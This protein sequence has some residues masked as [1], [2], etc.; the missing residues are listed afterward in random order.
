M[1]NLII[2]LI[3]RTLIHY[4]C[5][6]EH[7]DLSM[8][9]LLI[10]FQFDVNETDERN[11]TPLLYAARIGNFD[12]VEYLLNNSMVNKVAIDNEQ[13]NVLHMAC[14]SGS[15]RTAL[16][17]IEYAK[18]K[19]ILNQ[20]MRQKNNFKQT[21]LHF[22]AKLSMAPVIYQLLMSGASVND[23]DKYG[24]SA[25]L[26][27]AA[28]KLQAYCLA[29]IESFIQYPDDVP[30]ISTDLNE[31][32]KL[33]G[34]NQESSS[35][36]IKEQPTSS[37]LVVNGEVSILEKSTIQEKRFRRLSSINGLCDNFVQLSLNLT[38]N[39]WDSPEN[40]SKQPSSSII[41][42]KTNI[43]DNSVTIDSDSDLF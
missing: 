2:R 10:K 3:F 12:L 32:S 15:N 42:N 27:C 36:V 9:K 25:S 22:A 18:Q 24:Y 34:T 23:E 5:L 37:P 29:I 28:N 19:Q 17:I 1:K 31:E 41:N 7:K 35:E 16:L 30:S 13:N 21:C 38:N 11:R 8:L 4:C 39:S 26:Y 14:K 6:C 40:I 43:N 20:L 33:S